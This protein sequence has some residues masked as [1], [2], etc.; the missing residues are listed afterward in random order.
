MRVW[1]TAL[2]FL[3]LLLLFLSSRA[4][5][6]Q[7]R[8][9]TPQEGLLSRGP[10][11]ATL[12]CGAPGD[13]PSAARWL[14][15]GAPLSSSPSGPHRLLPDGSLLLLRPPARGRARS[16][17]VFTDQGIYTDQGVYTCEAIDEL[18]PGAGKGVRLPVAAL[19]EDFRLQ[20]RDV[21][22][23][24]GDRLVLECEPPRGHPE[25]TVSWRKDGEPLVP[26]TGRHVVSRGSLLVTRAE[27]S[28]SGNYVCVATNAAGQRESRTARVS[29]RVETPASARDEP[30]ELLVLRVQ[31]ENATVLTPGLGSASGPAVQLTWNEMG[32]AAPAQTYTAL[33]RARDPSGT[34]GSRGPGGPWVERPLKGRRRAELRGLD[35][36]RGYEIKVRPSSGRARGPDSNVLILQLPEKVPSAPPEAVTLYRGNDTIVASWAPPPRETRNGLILSYQLQCL[37]NASMPPANW[38]V[39]ASP[40]HAEI[41]AWAPGSYCVQVAAVTGAGAGALSR[42]VCILIELPREWEARDPGKAELLALEQLQETLSRPEVIAGAGAGLWLLLLGAAV[43]LRRRRRVRTGLA[44][45]ISSEG[46]SPGVPLLP[47]TRTFYGSLIAELPTGPP[48]PRPA[49]RL[50]PQLA[51]LS[52]PWPSSDSLCSLRRATPPLPPSIAHPTAWRRGGKLELH[53]ANSSPLPPFNRP[54]Q[55]WSWELGGIDNGVLPRRPRAVPRTRASWR[56][57]GTQLLGPLPP[58]PPPP[59]S[60]QHPSDRGTS[61]PWTSSPLPPA[62]PAPPPSSLNPSVSSRLSSSTL[63]SLGDDRD[64]VLTPED[65]ALCLE[66]GDGVEGPRVGSPLPRAPS[67]PTSFGYIPAAPGLV[68][69]AGEGPTAQASLCPARPGRTPSPS[70]ASLANGWGSASEDN[71]VSARTSLV[72]SSDGSFLA[73]ANFA[74]A[75]AVAVDSFCLSLET[76]ESDPVFADF[77]P[78]ASPLHGPFPAV[79]SLPSPVP[80]AGWDWME[81]M[82]ARYRLWL[83]RGPQARRP[84]SLGPS[85][86]IP[87][88]PIAEPGDQGRDGT[89]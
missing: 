13:P 10:G 6:S 49:R 81:E 83:G 53:Q 60:Q 69:G 23:G 76:G 34:E 15:D 85:P 74:R 3:G 29:I 64:N 84:A 1:D 5:E 51:R 26:V 11:T 72:S 12:S 7:P 82:E 28:D 59:Q 63:S 65:V 47:D 22:A 30:L 2:P 35:W 38:S 21:A 14:W 25:P 57:P 27:R 54:G 52:S 79:L 32:P 48:G 77:S 68:A 41:G 56:P 16:E 8:S 73:D 78:P 39:A 37:V 62:A 42:P 33:F 9:L 75:L 66:L 20:P 70:E 19:R 71:G 86:T 18:D 43:C 61:D 17:D 55:L 46:R 4:Q 44:S 36:G 40:T 88:Q 24:E 87:D 89:S 31:L 80:L 45:V 58:A 50:A 67:P